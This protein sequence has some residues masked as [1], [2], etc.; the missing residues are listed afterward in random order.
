MKRF[1]VILFMAFFM[2]ACRSPR[3]VTIEKPVTIHDT[4]E[5]VVERVDSVEIH[6][7][8][9]E[10]DSGGVVYIHDYVDRWHT[11]TVHDSVDRVVEVPVEVQV[12][13]PVEVVKEVPRKR[14]ALEKVLLA[15]G[16]LTI[17]SLIVYIV[18]QKKFK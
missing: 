5:R 1:V 18:W 4:V 14:S 17:V 3:V 8:H 12:S 9:S 13:V 2:V 11:N 16:C 6:H 7:Y 15:V 10:R